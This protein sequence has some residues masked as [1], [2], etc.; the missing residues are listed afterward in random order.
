[1]FAPVGEAELPQLSIQIPNFAEDP[2]GWQPTLDLART[3]D[4]AGVDRVV[5]SEHVLYGERLDAYGDPALGGTVGGRQPTSPDGH[6]LDPLT[7]LSVVAATTD[8]IR[9]ATAVVLAALRPPALLAKQAATLDVLSGGRLDLGVGVGWQREEYDSCGLDF[10]ARGALLDR[11]L[12]LCDRLWTESIVDFDDGELQFERIHAMPKPRQGGGVPIWVSGR[13]NPTTARRVARF[14]RGWI[15]WGDDIKDPRKGIDMMREAFAAA[16]RDPSALQ[17]QG[18]L[19]VVRNAHKV[20]VQATVEGVATLVGAG[21]TDFRFHNRWS[22]ERRAD[23][24][25]LSELVAA[26]RASVGRPALADGA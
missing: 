10:S 14:G 9:L 19:P 11:C 6:W 4:R 26:F 2:P 7:L 12:Y 3:A 15:P 13:A 17:V 25:L 1:M 22:L 23:E 18:T 16:G 5:V 21:I 24:T 20:D 8:R